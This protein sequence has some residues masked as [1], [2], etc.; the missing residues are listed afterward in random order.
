MSNIFFP[1]EGNFAGVLRPL[2]PPFVMAL[3]KGLSFQTAFK[4]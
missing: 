2:A 3:A 1:G 4:R